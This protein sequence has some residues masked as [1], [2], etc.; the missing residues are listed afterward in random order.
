MHH[1]APSSHLCVWVCYCIDDW[2]REDTLLLKTAEQC[3]MWVRLLLAC[4]WYSLQELES[5]EKW[6]Q[7]S[8]KWSLRA[9]PALLPGASLMVRLWFCRSYLWRRPWI[10]S[11]PRIFSVTTMSSSV[12]AMTD[13][14]C[15]CLFTGATLWRTSH[16]RSMVRMSYQTRHKMAITQQCALQC[17]TGGCCSCLFTGAT[18]WRP[19][20]FADIAQWPG[21]ESLGLKIAN[22]VKL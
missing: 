14:Y 21:W 22:H 15:S 6:P 3:R 9:R 2:Y 4:S 8:R 20:L 10:L 1:C 7:S 11:S 12:E 17:M 13:G 18:W 5:R 19:L 16:S